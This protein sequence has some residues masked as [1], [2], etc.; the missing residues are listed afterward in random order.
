M[1]RCLII[2]GPTASGKTPLALYLAR[3]LNGYII[4]ADS[5]QL[6]DHLKI[7][8]ARPIQDELEGVQR[9]FTPQIQKDG[10]DLI[11]YALDGVLSGNVRGS[12]GWWIKEAVSHMQAAFSQNKTPIIVGGTGLYIKGLMEGLSHIPDIS[13]D[14]QQE[15]RA[16]GEFHALQE[17]QGILS[18]L[19]PYAKN[20]KDKQR[21][22]RALEVIKGTG[23]PIEDFQGAKSPS[24]ECG[25][26][27][28]VLS[29]P[30]DYLY[31]RINKR[32]ELMMEQGALQEVEELLAFNLDKDH[33]VLK[34]TGVA[35]LQ[36]FLEKKISLEE[37]VEKGKQ[38]TRQYAK[39]Q[40]TWFRRQIQIDLAMDS[41]HLSTEEQV[42]RIIAVL[43]S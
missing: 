30:R 42:E 32:F 11:P 9:I 20:Y 12:V 18:S 10:V 33:P 36:Q 2:T 16:L 5:M 17:L 4:N 7:L 40:M 8:T 39:R 1:N 13:R 27:T 25:Y 15:V 23:V 3:I 37:A 21:L 26:T 38:D 31:E 34:A 43:Q 29:P 35:P 28:A 22:L 6:Y 24:I 19:N 14:I 41:C